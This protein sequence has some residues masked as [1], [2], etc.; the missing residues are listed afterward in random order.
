[1]SYEMYTVLTTRTQ[2][3]FNIIIDYTEEDSTPNDTY[4]EC[5]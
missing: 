3:N 2:D 1:M 5:D 4:A